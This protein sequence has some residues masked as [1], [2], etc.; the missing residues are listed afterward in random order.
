MIH[1]LARAYLESVRHG[2]G[3]SAT[4]LAWLGAGAPIDADPPPNTVK[5]RI[6]VAV[7]PRGLWNCNGWQGAADA[8]VVESLD[9]DGDRVTWITAHVPLPEP[10]AEVAGE[11]EGG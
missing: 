10:A 11:V 6:A 1:P 5:V 9:A 8:Q 4:F 3:D 7:D 2:P